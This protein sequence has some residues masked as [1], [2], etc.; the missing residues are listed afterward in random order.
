[1]NL[2]RA[3]TDLSEA[4]SDLARS[5]ELFEDLLKNKTN[6][7]HDDDCVFTLNVPKNMND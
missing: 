7:N 1:M 6:D 2:C 3:L 4:L 5:V